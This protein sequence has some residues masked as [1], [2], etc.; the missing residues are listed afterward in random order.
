MVGRGGAGQ[1]E[2]PGADDSAD[3]EK[4]ERRGRERAVQLLMT[5]R[6]G[7]LDF[8]D[9]LGGKKLAWHA[10]GLYTTG[11]GKASKRDGGGRAAPADRRKS[12]GAQYFGDVRR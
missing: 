3:T 1:N 2:N 4:G 9:R 12:G 5:R 6:V 7:F 11:P 10:A 8:G